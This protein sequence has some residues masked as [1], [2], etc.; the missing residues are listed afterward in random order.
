[1][2]SKG[3]AVRSRAAV[4]LDVLA[5]HRSQV[6]D[7]ALRAD[8]RRE[9]ARRCTQR[10]SSGDTLGDVAADVE[11]ELDGQVGLAECLPGMAESF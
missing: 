1:M 6:L 10:G 9:W 4:P 5:L 7:Q 2:G 3:A 11:V 8:R